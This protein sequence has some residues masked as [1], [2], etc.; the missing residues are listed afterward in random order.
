M[1]MD[2]ESGEFAVLPRLV[3]LGVLCRLDAALIEYHAEQN[4]AWLPLMRA[5]GAPRLFKDN[6]E[7]L[8]RNAGEG[9]GVALGYLSAHAGGS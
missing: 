2:I 6:V 1:K 4:P 9:C 5:Y 3:S 8:V 7:Y